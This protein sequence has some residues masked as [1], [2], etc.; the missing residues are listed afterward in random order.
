[1]PHLRRTAF[2]VSYC[3]LGSCAKTAI[4]GLQV[5]KHKSDEAVVDDIYANAEEMRFTK[6]AQSLENKRIYLAIGEYDLVVPSAPLEEFWK[7]LPKTGA[8]RGRKCYR[9]SHSLMGARLQLANDIISF[10]QNDHGKDG[11][12]VKRFEPTAPL[13]EVEKAAKAEIN[14]E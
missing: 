6:A 8:K 9:T 12:V 13:E 10:I 2:P 7:A 1:M 11:R 5:L 3:G 14:K 4:K